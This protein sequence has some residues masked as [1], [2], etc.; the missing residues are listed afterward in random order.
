V[1]SRTAQHSPHSYGKPSNAVKRSRRKYH[2]LW[3]WVMAA[4]RYLRP[5]GVKDKSLSACIVLQ[6][7]R[8]VAAFTHIAYHSQNVFVL[9]V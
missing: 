7:L 5:A 2:Y 1:Q 6:C 3:L 4:W 9:W 8:V